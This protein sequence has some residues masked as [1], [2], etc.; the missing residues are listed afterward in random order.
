[1]T[2]AIISFVFALFAVCFNLYVHIRLYGPK[3]M[4]R[5]E[6]CCRRYYEREDGN[7]KGDC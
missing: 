2:L 4:K 5:Y 7:D 3:S 1:M 6:E